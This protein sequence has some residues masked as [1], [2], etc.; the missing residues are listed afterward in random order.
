MADAKSRAFPLEAATAM[1]E[2]VKVFGR[3]RRG[4]ECLLLTEEL[5]SGL[6]GPIFHF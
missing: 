2:S 5:K 3:D 4:G 1:S 6:R